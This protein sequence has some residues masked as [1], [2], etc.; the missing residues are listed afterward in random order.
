MPIDYKLLSRDAEKLFRGGLVGESLV[1]GTGALLTMIPE[2]RDF[3]YLCMR[4]SAVVACINAPAWLFLYIAK[5]SY[6]Q[7]PPSQTYLRD[8]SLCDKIFGYNE[9][10]Y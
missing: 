6:E 2:A 4:T 9:E 3:G 8:T 1:F 7:E 10:D 5:K